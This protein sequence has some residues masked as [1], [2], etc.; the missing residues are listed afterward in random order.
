MANQLYQPMNDNWYFSSEQSGF[1]RLHP[2]ITCLLKNSDA[3]WFN[4]LDLGKLVRLVFIELTEA[5]DAVA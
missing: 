4:E 3:D 2:T 1:L 5:F